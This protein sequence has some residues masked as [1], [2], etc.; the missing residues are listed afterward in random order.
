MPSF[1]PVNEPWLTQVKAS[2]GAKV[3]LDINAQARY[4]ALP[5]GS[6]VSSGITEVHS[7]G[8]KKNDFRP[9]ITALTGSGAQ[10]PGWTRDAVATGVHAFTFA[11]TNSTTSTPAPVQ[12]FR[13]ATG[14]NSYPFFNHL[15]N[16]AGNAKAYT[17]FFV[18]K[19]DTAP[20]VEASIIDL[21]VQG[22]TY[23]WFVYQNATN[24]L[25]AQVAGTQSFTLGTAGTSWHVIC[26]TSNGTTTTGY[27]SSTTSA[28]SCS[29]GAKTIDVGYMGAYGLIASP[30]EQ[31]NVKVG[32]FLVLDKELDS[33]NR[34]LVMRKLGKQYGVT[35]S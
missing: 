18:V 28:G 7:N 24:Y 11:G 15:T 12:Y 10:N 2:A 19:T 8:A 31:A 17:A 30:I 9:Y 21:G 16:T 26:I 3:V 25:F 33:T 27:L 5:V 22:A 13:W 14:N 23:D 29:E 32:R 20:A 1:E 35:I 4:L 6:T 34:N